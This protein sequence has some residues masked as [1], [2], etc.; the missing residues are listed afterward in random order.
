MNS[1]YKMQD[2]ETTNEK[3]KTME[4][5]HRMINQQRNKIENDYAGG[6]LYKGIS[7]WLGEWMHTKQRPG[8]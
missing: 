8:H 7:N 1:Q 2:E 3:R 5:K 6:D 4:R